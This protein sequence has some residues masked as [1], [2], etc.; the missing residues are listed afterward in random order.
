MKA[1]TKQ[2]GLVVFTFLTLSFSLIAQQTFLESLWVTKIDYYVNGEK[3]GHPNNSQIIE[4]D[5]NGIPVDLR[6]IGVDI[7]FS[8]DLEK[9]PDILYVKRPT[10]K[11]IL[12]LA[13]DEKND[14]KYTTEK[15][16]ILDC[17]TC[18]DSIFGEESYC[19]KARR[20]NGDLFYYILDDET[21]YVRTHRI[22]PAKNEEL[23]YFYITPF[24]TKD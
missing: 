10:V 21:H 4:Y 19:I 13:N 15:M 1:L 2:I 6:T 5:A 16:M 24:D 22:S 18:N 20:Y 7:K 23:I 11:S 12:D 3:K 17:G 9:A 8:E 14:L